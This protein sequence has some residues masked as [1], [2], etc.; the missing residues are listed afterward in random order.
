[1]GQDYQITEPVAISSAGHYFLFFK[2]EDYFLS[3]KVSGKIC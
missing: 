3:L 2:K 1:M